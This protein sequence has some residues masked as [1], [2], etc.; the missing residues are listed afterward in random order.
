MSRVILQDIISKFSP[1]KFIRFF[2]EKNRFFVPRHEE[3]RQY[4]DNSFRNG[5]KLGEINFQEGERFIICAFLTNQSLSER[6]EKKDQYEKGKKILKESQNDAGIFIFY[7]QSGNFRFSLIYS[8]YLGRRRDWSTFRRFTYFV[9]REL[10]NK[11]FLQRIGGG[12][13]SSLAEIK[14][15]FSVEKV[16][17]EFY[18][19]IANWYF[20]A[21]KHCRFPKDAEVEDNGR[22]I[23]VIR[24]ITRMIFIWFMRE[25][26][27]VPKELFEEKNARSVLKDTD[28]NSATYYR[29]ILQNLFFATLSTKKDDRQFR[30]EVRG[31]RGKNPDF[32]NQYVYR[33]H[34]LFAEP[35][36]IKSYFEEIPFLNGGLFECL[37]EKTQK[38][39]R[40]IDGFTAT[41]K[42]QP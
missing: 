39:Y 38:P 23:A 6:S 2:R 8:N 7:D 1:N 26:G 14:E 41:K 10:T 4:S 20:L 21:V 9:S 42:H 30:S 29:A 40:Y 31:Y 27:L 34:E 36:K 3:L 24:L 22:N 5:L 16:T 12:D 32:G 13:F 11:T 17:K 19:D 28:P 15:A 25:R 33:Y 37:D 35:D 18:K